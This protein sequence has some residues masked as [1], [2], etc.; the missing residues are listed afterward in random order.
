[1]YVY[2]PKFES[3]LRGEVLRRLLKTGV[4]TLKK[5]YEVYILEVFERVWKV[6][7]ESKKSVGKYLRES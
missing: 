5:V 4:Y 2:T 6:F 7:E 3:R 1:M